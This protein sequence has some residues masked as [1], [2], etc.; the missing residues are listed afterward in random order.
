MITK[1]DNQLN[2]LCVM[3]VL[4]QFL[5]V[6]DHYVSSDFS[7]IRKEMEIKQIL[8][9]H[10]PNAIFALRWFGDDLDHES[11]ESGY[12]DSSGFESDWLWWNPVHRKDLYTWTDNLINNPS[13]TCYSHSL[14][15]RVEGKKMATTGAFTLIIT[16]KVCKQPTVLLL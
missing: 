2:R 4:H 16:G 7:P 5:Q 11:H 1:N 10:K 12:S 6:H 9:H 13:K 15:R 3:R 14:L 8:T